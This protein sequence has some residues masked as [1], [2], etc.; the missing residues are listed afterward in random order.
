M[1]LNRRQALGAFGAVGL[2]ALLP[3]CGEDELARS[4]RVTAESTE[5][6]FYFDADAIRRDI[7]EDRQGVELRLMLRVREA[8][9]CTPIP[10][11]VVDVWH[12]DAQGEY[13]AAGE[14]FLRGAQVTDREGVA[15]LVTVYPGWYQGRTPHIHAKVHLDKRT[16]LTTQVFFDDALSSKVYRDRRYARGEQQEVDNSADSIF[17]EALVLSTRRRGSGWVGALTFDVERA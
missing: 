7:R 16:V 11:A 10:N 3:G 17:D 15:E 2:G 5:G 9:R 13:S 1:D 14:R 8:D 4:C 12:C 6:P